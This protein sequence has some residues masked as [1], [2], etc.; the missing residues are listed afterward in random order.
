AMDS[1][2]AFRTGRVRFNGHRQ[3]VT[4]ARTAK[5]FVRR[6][7]IGRFWTRRV[8]QLATRSPRSRRGFA[9][10]RTLPLAIARIVLVAA[11]P[12]LAVPHEVIVRPR[13]TEKLEH[14]SHRRKQRATAFPKKQV[15]RSSSWSAS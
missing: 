3:P 11:L 4:A 6:H 2:A 5:H 9:D 15:L 12:I 7:Q 13:R 1:D 10:V 8:L 14:G